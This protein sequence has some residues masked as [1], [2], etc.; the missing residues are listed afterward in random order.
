M[1]TTND[2]ANSTASDYSSLTDHRKHQAGV[3]YPDGGLPNIEGYYDCSQPWCGQNGHGALYASSDTATIPN[4]Q[5]NASRINRVTLNAHNSNTTYG[6]YQ[7]LGSTGNVIP[8]HIAV[9][10]WQREE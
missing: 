5:S 1:V 3:K 6:Q 10:A 4:G 2:D 9:I 8:S 7:V